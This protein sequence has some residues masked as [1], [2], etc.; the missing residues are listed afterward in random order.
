M[1]LQKSGKI[2]IL[3]YGAWLLILINVLNANTAERINM[4]EGISKEDLK[5]KLSTLYW[6]TDDC[7][8]LITAMMCECKE[9]DPWLP[10][11][12]NT[13]KDRMI[14]IWDDNYGQCT[15]IEEVETKA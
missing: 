3:A 8:Q 5:Y 2:L 15:H 11:D 9:L 14:L 6:S 4:T 12:E 10:I 1:K 13:P 7:N